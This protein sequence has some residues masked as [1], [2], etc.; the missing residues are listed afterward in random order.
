M[1]ESRRELIAEVL[2]RVNERPEAVEVLKMVAREFKLPPFGDADF[3]SIDR[4]D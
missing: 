2:I 3:E 4:Q 1:E